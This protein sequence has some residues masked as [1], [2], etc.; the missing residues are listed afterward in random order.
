[1]LVS[2]QH[3]LSDLSS[4]TGLYARIARQADRPALRRLV[5]L[6]AESQLAHAPAAV[7]SMMA[8]IR[9]EFRAAD[10][11]PA[12]D[13]LLL[14]SKPQGEILVGLVQADWSERSCIHV[15]DFIVHPDHRGRGI[16]RAILN[17]LCTAATSSRR[18]VVLE[19]FYD[20]PA[21]HLASRQG[22]RVVE[23]TGPM[24]RLEWAA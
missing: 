18:R 13:V 3:F 2:Q 20:S 21:R 10:A 17:A 1:M 11:R 16:G 6:D 5:A 8:A 24:T 7:R 23:D 14:Q 4:R 12:V 22:F 9:A 15:R 19:M